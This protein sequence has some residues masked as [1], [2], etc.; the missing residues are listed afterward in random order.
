MQTTSELW[1]KTFANLNH[2]GE[3]RVVIGGVEY[4]A[5]S[6]KEAKATRFLLMKRR[7]WAMPAPPCWI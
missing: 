6:L 7:A 4:G 3:L 1:K 2:T 5:G